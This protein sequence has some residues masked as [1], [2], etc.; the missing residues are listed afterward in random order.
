[1]EKHSGEHQKKPLVEHLKLAGSWVAFIQSNLDTVLAKVEAPL[2]IRKTAVRMKPTHIISF[3]EDLM[4]L[5]VI[6]VEE[7]KKSIPLDGTEHRDEFFGKEYTATAEVHNDG[8]IIVTGNLG[9]MVVTTVREIDDASQMVL[10]TI[11]DDVKCVT[12]FARPVHG[13]DQ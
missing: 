13:Q 7:K 3:E 11:V 12:V 9:D 1:M 8:S 6:R 4:K 2:S 10:T 5:T